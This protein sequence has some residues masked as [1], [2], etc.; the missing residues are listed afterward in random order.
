M[1]LLKK[2]AAGLLPVFLLINALHIPVYAAEEEPWAAPP[3]P[4][5]KYVN[6]RV[7]LRN[8]PG[9]DKDVLKTINRGESVDFVAIYNY[10][11]SAVIY[12]ETK[13]FIKS[14]FLSSEK[15]P[16]PKVELMN[17][18]D[19]K[20]ILET[21][22]AIPVY[23]VGTGLTYNVKSFS[24]G[25]HAD[26]EPATEEDTAIMKRTYNNHWSWDGRPVWVTIAGHTIAAAINGMPHGGG[27]ISDDGMDGQVC[28]H[29]KGSTVHNGNMV[30]SRQLQD[31]VMQ[32]YN[33][34]LEE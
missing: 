34:A 5:V 17:W 19:V 28:L 24:N 27:V 8:G 30:Y 2:A 18:S 9:T 29:F 15:P 3:K 10:E 21:G 31:V 4:V 25:M 23:D 6:D 20:P 13:G 12:G 16:E 33:A 1:F 22:V 7:N 26:V 32:A 14:E 11:W